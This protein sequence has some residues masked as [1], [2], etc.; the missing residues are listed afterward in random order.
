MCMHMCI[1]VHVHMC[2]HIHM[3][4]KGWHQESSIISLHLTIFSLNLRI[5]SLIEPK[6]HWFARLL[7][8]RIPGIHLSSPNPVPELQMYVIMPIFYVSSGDLNW[9]PNIWVQSTLSSESLLSSLEVGFLS[10]NIQL[11]I[12]FEVHIISWEPRT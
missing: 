9:D 1:L 3:R 12:P 8:Q 4:A 10:C 2:M 11:F 7:G 6:A 5:W